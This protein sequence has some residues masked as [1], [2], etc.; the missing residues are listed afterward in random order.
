[1][2]N[3]AYFTRWVEIHY[4]LSSARGSDIARNSPLLISIVH[5]RN[6]MNR[7]AVKTGPRGGHAERGF[8]APRTH[9]MIT[10]SSSVRVFSKSFQKVSSDFLQSEPNFSLNMVPRWSKARFHMD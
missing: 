2:L 8:P 5:I 10:P 1:M 6:T 9:L 7:L 4:R 3:Y